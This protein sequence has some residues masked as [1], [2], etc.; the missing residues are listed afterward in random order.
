[1]SY[2]LDT[3]QPHE[4]AAIV[5]ERLKKAYKKG[6]PVYPGKGPCGGCDL[7]IPEDP[8]PID[9]KKMIS[10]LKTAAGANEPV[11]AAEGPCGACD[12]VVH[13]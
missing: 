6:L 3:T 8:K 9:V 11:Y 10:K 5:L 12:V 1:M 2:L 7:V 4:H 13:G